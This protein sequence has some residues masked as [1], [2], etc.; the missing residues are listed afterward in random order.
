M[1][2]VRCEND[3]VRNHLC[4]MHIQ[5]FGHHYGKAFKTIQDKLEMQKAQTQKAWKE[6][7][8]QRTSL[9]ELRELTRRAWTRI[10]HQFSIG[11]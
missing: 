8:E 9:P 10:K 6:Y 11:E 1:K 4:R 7:E 5:A 3:A 2:G